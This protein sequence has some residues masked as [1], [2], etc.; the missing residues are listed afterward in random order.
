MPRSWQA[1]RSEALQHAAVAE[2]QLAEHRR[3]EAVHRA[4]ELE[5]QQSVVAPCGLVLP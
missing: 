5:E 2:E 1:H 4:A 3:A